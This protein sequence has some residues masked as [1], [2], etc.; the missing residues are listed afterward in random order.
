MKLLDSSDSSRAAATDGH[1]QR[2]APSSKDTSTACGARRSRAI[3]SSPQRC[4][5][6]GGSLGRGK[7]APA[8]SPKRAAAEPGVQ[9]VKATV[10]PE[11]VTRKASATATSGRGAKTRPKTDSTASKRPAA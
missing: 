11:R 8:T 10:P 9:V 3:S 1:V 4:G 6:G 5:A 2:T 7:Y